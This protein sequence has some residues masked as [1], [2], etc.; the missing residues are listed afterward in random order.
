MWRE[1][2]VVL[3]DVVAFLVAALRFFGGDCSFSPS[4]ATLG[5]AARFLG[6]LLLLAVTVEG[7]EG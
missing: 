4:L 6:V 5:A 7:A 3:V 1:L 2:T